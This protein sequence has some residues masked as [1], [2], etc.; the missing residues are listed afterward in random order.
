MCLCAHMYG[1]PGRIGEGAGSPG[2]G[3]IS[4]CGFA[5]NRYWKLNSGLL[6][7]CVLFI[8]EP[9][10]RPYLVCFEHLVNTQELIPCLRT[11]REDSAM[12][13]CTVVCAHVSVIVGLYY[14]GC[15]Q[16]YPP[17]VVPFSSNL[18]GPRVAQ[19]PLECSSVPVSV[20]VIFPP[21]SDLPLPIPSL[22]LHHEE[23]SVVNQARWHEP[24]VPA[25][26]ALGQ[27]AHNVQS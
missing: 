13:E 15:K 19:N 12:C 7:Q 21:L 24:V 1:Y 3:V 20:S 6:Q 9:F 23:Y 4:S 5:Q 14:D 26:R 22:F 25:L 27:K 16:R 8:A 17:A 18:L 2:S 11:K 10:S